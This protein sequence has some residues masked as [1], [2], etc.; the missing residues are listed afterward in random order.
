MSRDYYRAPGGQ[1]L[2]KAARH[3]LSRLSGEELDYIG[4][5]RSVRLSPNNEPHTLAVMMLQSDYDRAVTKALLQNL[6]LWALILFFAVSCCMFSAAG[7][8]RPFSKDWSR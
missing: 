1:L 5:T 6:I 8:W 4:I 3:G 2:V 7:I